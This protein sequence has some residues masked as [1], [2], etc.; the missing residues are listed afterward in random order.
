MRKLKVT[1]MGRMSVAEY[2]ESD[3]QPLVVVLD[4]VRSLY[5]VGSVFRTS[6]AFRVESVLLCGITA[7]PPHPEIHKTALGAEE[8]VDWHYYERTEDAVAWLKEEGYTVLAIEQCEGSTMLQDFRTEAGRKY[9]VVLGNEVKGV[10]QE[11]VDSCDGCL[12]IPQYGTKH[13]LNVSVAAGIV[14]WHMSRK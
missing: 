10:Q 2:R 1:E 12:E 4:H 7:R 5:N 8:S 13:S 14:L 9:A 11:V 6:D 3:K